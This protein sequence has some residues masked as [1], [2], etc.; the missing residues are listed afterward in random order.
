MSIFDQIKLADDLEAAVLTTIESWFPVYVR[1]VELQATIPQDSLPLPKSYLT[2][3]RVDRNNADQLPSIVVVSPGLSGKRPLQEGDGTFRCF[4]S[5]GVG[6]FVAGND[7]TTTKRLVRTY[8]AVVRTIMLQKQS[9]GGFAAGTNWL[10]ESY[11]DDFNFTDN[12]TIGAG[13]VVLEVEV[14]G[15]V[16]RFAGP[17]VYGGPPPDPDPDTQPGSDWGTSDTVS[18]FI[19]VEE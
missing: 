7:R 5:I 11:D 1:E 10:D 18:A 13:Q 15:V 3:D 8:T 12:Q 2:A 14:D 19:E 17:A 6:I 16:N 9:L 4:F